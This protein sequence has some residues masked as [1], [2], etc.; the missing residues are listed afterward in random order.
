MKK[1]LLTLISFVSIYFSIAAFNT[2]SVKADVRDV[3]EMAA[4]VDGYYGDTYTCPN[5]KSVYRCYDG[6]SGCK[7]SKQGLC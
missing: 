2:N 5:G 4:P 3:E 7:V 6:G 1:L